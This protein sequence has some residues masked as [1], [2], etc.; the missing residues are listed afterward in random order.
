M[1]EPLS[2]LIEG[3]VAAAPSLINPVYPWISAGHILA[4]ALLVGAIATLDLRLLGAFRATPVAHLARPLVR[5][6]GVGLLLAVLTGLLLFSVQPDHY[7]G[8]AAFLAKLGIVAA[9]ILHALVV[10]ALPGWRDVLCGSPVPGTLRLAGGVSL[11][12]WVAA[13]FAGRWIAFL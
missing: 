8:N 3:W 10:R 1:T 5:V 4:L 13:V 9:G 6:A 12:T 2:A 7:L 11:A